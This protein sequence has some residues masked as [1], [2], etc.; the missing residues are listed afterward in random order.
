[1]NDAR[2]PAIAEA[3]LRCAAVREAIAEQ[4]RRLELLRHAAQLAEALRREAVEL[5]RKP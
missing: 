3:E 5:R 4:E 2:R 1:M